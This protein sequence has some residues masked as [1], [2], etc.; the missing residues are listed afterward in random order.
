MGRWMG[1]L[2][3]VGRNGIRKRKQRNSDLALASGAIL[4]LPWCA[5]Y[6]KDHQAIRCPGDSGVAIGWNG[7]G[8]NRDRDQ[9]KFSRAAAANARHHALFARTVQATDSV[10]L[11]V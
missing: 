9:N 6:E 5:G 4:A 11:R 3:T 10:H 1:F 7:P 8:R 2:P